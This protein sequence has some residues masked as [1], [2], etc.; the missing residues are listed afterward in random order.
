MEILES[1]QKWSEEG[2]RVVGIEGYSGVGKT[3]FANLIAKEIANT[4]VF[5][6]DDFTPA[7]DSEEFIKSKD[8]NEILNQYV[9][10]QGVDELIQ[11]I[12]Q[13]DTTK[14]IIVE[15]P[16]LLH[17]NSLAQTI[18]RLIYIDADFDTADTGR[19]ER[20]GFK[21]PPSELKAL[22]DYF[23]KAY[24]FYLDEY[25]VKEQADLVVKMDS[26]TPNMF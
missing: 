1:I 24:L 4:K 2:V 25:R 13:A 5:S 12:R 16:F 8:S 10:N 21:E 19:Y 14:F 22:S 11:A 18:E 26:S 6:V 15:G 3:T 9:K 7:V 23:K 20:H 17:D